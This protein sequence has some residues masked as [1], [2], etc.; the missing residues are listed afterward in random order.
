MEHKKQYFIGGVVIAVV[1]MIATV[2]L[3]RHFEEPVGENHE[4]TLSSRTVGVS[5]DNQKAIDTPATNNG[6]HIVNAAIKK[7][8]IEGC[9]LTSCDISIVDHI[10][11]VPDL[12]IQNLNTMITEDVLEESQTDVRNAPT[13]LHLENEIDFVDNYTFSITYIDNNLIGF[14]RSLEVDYKDTSHP[15]RD[16]GTYGFFYIQNGTILRDFDVPLFKTNADAEKVLKHFY[17]NGI[18]VLV[19]RTH[20][21]TDFD[22]CMQSATFPESF[23]PSLNLKTS[24]IVFEPSYPY[25]LTGKCSGV[26]QFSIPVGE[27][28]KQSSEYVPENSV[29]RIL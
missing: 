28:L 14:Y 20:D 3:L 29:L 22:E 21:D 10:D 13:G 11:G 15:T 4:P 26:L 1:L 2:I 16:M 23:L 24:E 17:P 5:L 12:L 6:L 7:I 8:H 27:I 18:E 9:S 25:A 19:D